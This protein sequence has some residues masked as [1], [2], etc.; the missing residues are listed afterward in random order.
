VIPNRLESAPRWP[1]GLTMLGNR[2]IQ[3][4]IRSNYVCFPAQ[5]PIFG[6]R[7]RRNLQWRLAVLYFVQG[8][9]TRAIAERYGLRRERC[10]QIIS[11]WRI[12]AIALGYIQD[13]TPEG[14]D[15]DAG[16][17]R[18]WRDRANAPSSGG[19]Q[20]AVK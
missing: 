3:T 1:M 15:F 18:G 6:E 8:W 13:V 5:A 9:T 10:G 20:G 4:L 19:D 16:D 2:E 11:D 12:R 17:R 14:A 7:S